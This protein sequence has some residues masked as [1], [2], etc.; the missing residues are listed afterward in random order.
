MLLVGALAGFGISL[1]ADTLIPFTGD[2]PTRLFIEDGAK[3]FGVV[4]WAQY[5]VV[6]TLDITRSTVTGREHPAPRRDAVD[7]RQPVA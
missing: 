2:S 4:A 1:A 5:F 3:L 7:R 6:T